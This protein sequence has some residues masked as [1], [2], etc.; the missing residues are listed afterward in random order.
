MKTASFN[1]DIPASPTTRRNRSNNGAIA[2]TVLGQSMGEIKILKDQGASSLFSE[3]QLRR[4]NKK[5][6]KALNSNLLK[7]NQL[8]TAVRNC[9]LEVGSYYEVKRDIYL[10]KYGHHDHQPLDMFEV[11]EKIHMKEF[12]KEDKIH[13]IQALLKHEFVID[14]LLDFIEIGSNY[15]WAPES[16]TKHLGRAC[17]VGSTSAAQ[18]YNFAGTAASSSQISRPFTGY[19]SA[20]AR[21]NT[22]QTGHKASN[23]R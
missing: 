2:E 20:M 19:S 8:V 16:N 9:I 23:L 17:G 22:G 14:R 5:L 7:K 18:L 6:K 3:P 1:I 21:P 10:C 12:Q 4:E 15:T 11:D 13:V